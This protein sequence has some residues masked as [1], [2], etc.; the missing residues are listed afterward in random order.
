MGAIPVWQAGISQNFLAAARAGASDHELLGHDAFVERM[1]GVEQQREFAVA[2]DFEPH[3]GDVTQFALV[4]HYG[5]RALFLF[6]DAQR[7]AAAIGQDRS[8]PAARAERADRCQRQ[9]V[10]IEGQDRPV[11]GQVV[12]CLLYTSPSPRDRQK[13]RMPSSA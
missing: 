6:E 5:H 13:S 7:D 11:G 3:R 8:M 9:Q 10:R 12:C 2:R 4:G 1:T